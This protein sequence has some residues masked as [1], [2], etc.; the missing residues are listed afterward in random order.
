MKAIRLYLIA[1]VLVEGLMASAQEIEIKGP[2]AGQPAVRRLVQY[3]KFRLN[4]VPSVAMTFGDDYYQNV[5]VGVR[6]GYGLFDWLDIGGFFIYGV[7][8]F[9]TNLTKAIQKVKYRYAPK[10]FSKYLS[11][12]QYIGGGQATFYPLR[13][14]FTLL[15]KVQF[16]MDIFAFGGV[17][18][19]GVK[20]RGRPS[21][22][23][24]D[25]KIVNTNVKK[26]EPKVAPTFGGG[27]DLFLNKFC[28]VSLEYRLTPFSVNTSGRNVHLSSDEVGG[29]EP[30]IILDS[31]DE[32]LVMNHM[33]SLGFVL[34]F[35][36]EPKISD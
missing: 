26:S 34:F 4:L 8:H 2:L 25:R 3:H 21:G 13:G 6:G 33:L 9:R 22:T 18:M 19:A 32:K 28:G 36:F 30:R 11:Y 17:A 23:W 12:I 20:R 27:L 14:K 7:H 1:L 5:L 35:P 10:S 29:G 31:K 16:A 24:D 15:G